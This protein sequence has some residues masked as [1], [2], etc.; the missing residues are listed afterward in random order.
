M[1]LVGLFSGPVSAGPDASTFSVSDKTILEVIG[2]DCYCVH[3][4]Q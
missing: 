1:P 4:Y 3:R 2:I